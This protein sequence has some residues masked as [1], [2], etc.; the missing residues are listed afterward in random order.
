M[1]CNNEIK[2]ESL[3]MRDNQTDGIYIYICI[4]QSLLSMGFYQ[5]EIIV[6]GIPLGF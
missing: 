4:M 6:I 1:V 2:Y 5:Q 3:A